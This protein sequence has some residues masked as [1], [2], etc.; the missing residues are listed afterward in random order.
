MDKAPGHIDLA[1]IVEKEVRIDT[2]KVK[3][4]GI[5]VRGWVGEIVAGD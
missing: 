5:A 4:H 2:V 1:I 3:G